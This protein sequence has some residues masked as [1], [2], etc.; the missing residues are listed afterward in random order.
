MTNAYPLSRHR[1]PDEILAIG[2]AGPVSVATFLRE[3]TALAR[4]LPATASI[5]NL[6]TDRYRFT[7]GLAAALLRRQIT[8]LPPS[9]NAA[10][11]SGL[12]ADF[13]DAAILHDR[14][15]AVDAMPA[16]AYP[17]KFDSSADAVEMPMIPAEQPAIVLFTSG[18]TGR[19]LPHQKTWGSLVLSA[20]AAGKALAIGDLPHATVIATVP[21]Q[22]SYGFESTVMLPLQYGLALHHARPFYPADIAAAIEAAPRP[23]ILVTS[24]VHLRALLA[25]AT[26]LP[27]L[28]LI[29]SATAPLARDLAIEAERVFAERLLEIYGCSEAGQL[30]T[31]RTAQRLEWRCMDGI[32]LR[33]AADTTFASGPTIANEIALGDVI[34]LAGDGAFLLRG[35]NA[36]LVNIGGKRTSL[37][38]LNHHLN[39]IE[40]VEDGVFIMPGEDDDDTARLIALVVAPRLTAAA[41][42]AAL[43]TRIDPV[44]LPRP[45]RL[46]DALPR[47]EVGKITREAALQA[48]HSPAHRERSP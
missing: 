28:D 7:V 23:R 16:L 46:L 4:L 5:V 18:S 19:P 22:H 1:H 42:M 17:D 36:D 34:D 27:P 35:R 47:N 48:A 25:D 10:I 2:S 9:D 20:L 39:A 13:P 45:L 37:A 31:R 8:L 21:Q 11:L 43:R 29:V 33:Q 30:A 24:P 3:A 15:I 38:H 12:R 32:A 44:F 40:G 26:V 6:C 14:A 41:I